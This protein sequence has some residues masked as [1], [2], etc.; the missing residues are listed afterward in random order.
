MKF[1][2]WNNI[3]NAIERVD[4]CRTKDGKLLLV[5]LEDLNPYLSLLD[6][7][8]DTRKKFVNDLIEVIK[9]GY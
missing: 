6:L 2:K 7:D 1:I 5:E 9:V 3:N 4:A 8:E